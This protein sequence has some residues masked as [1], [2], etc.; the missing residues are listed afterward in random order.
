[1][2]EKEK[3]RAPVARR[4]GAVSHSQAPFIAKDP[5]AGKLMPGARYWLHVSDDGVE[6]LWKSEP[7]HVPTFTVEVVCYGGG[8]ARVL[9][10]LSITEW[11]WTADPERNK[12]R[13]RG[14]GWR[15]DRW[16]RN[17]PYPGLERWTKRWVRHRTW[18]LVEG[19]P[20]AT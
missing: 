20:W 17:D 19:V 13:P 1:M 16:Q 12:A 11:A 5:V 15:A 6:T 3:P 18:P 10:K 4:D 8:T 2:T 9:D 14:Q 7:A